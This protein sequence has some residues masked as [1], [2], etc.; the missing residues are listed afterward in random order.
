MAK[1]Q[2][3]LH[4]LLD[5]TSELLAIA[6]HRNAAR[7]TRRAPVD[8]GAL[9]TR[10]HQV[11]LE[12]AKQRGLTLALEVV[13][14]GDALQVIGDEQL[15]EQAIENLVS[16]A[17]KYTREGRVTVR[18][19]RSGPNVVVEVEDTGIGIPDAARGKLFSEF[20]RAK[21]AKDVDPGG[22][23]LGLAATRQTVLEHGGSI[24]VDSR[25]NAGSRFTI[26]LP[27]LSSKLTAPPSALS[28]PRLPSS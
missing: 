12:R 23:G 9:A 10:I 25:E 5:T 13:G 18:V 19:S 3:R 7:E 1:L 27:S 17:V 26:A 21:N 28:L 2:R 4:G 6:R 16:N 11:F 20:F 24:E 14:E 15:L 22:T 8:L